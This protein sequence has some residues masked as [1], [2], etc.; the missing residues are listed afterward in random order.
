MIA[1]VT[2][3]C[4]IFIEVAGRAT[5]LIYVQWGFFPNSVYIAS[6]IIYQH[7]YEEL[8]LRELYIDRIST[9][10][11]VHCIKHLCFL[12]CMLLRDKNKLNVII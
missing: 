5:L 11:Q 3:Y 2:I 12:V 9:I 7:V 10:C 6:P 1:A 4:F 8:L